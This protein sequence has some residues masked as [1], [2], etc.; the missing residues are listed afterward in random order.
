MPVKYRTVFN[1][2]TSI[3]LTYWK[4]KQFNKWWC[5]SQ[6][7]NQFYLMPKSIFFW[8]NYTSLRWPGNNMEM[9]TSF[10]GKWALCFLCHQ[11][12]QNSLP[13]SL[14][15]CLVHHY[16]S[17]FI[18]E[19]FIDFIPTHFHNH[20][21]ILLPHPPFLILSHVFTLMYE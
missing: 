2:E 1:N 8:E 19:N 6:D 3:T 10:H 7:S 13:S 9:F 20:T 4:W 17:E 16:K 14:E 21:T 15:L 18:L 5:Q 11:Y 12:S